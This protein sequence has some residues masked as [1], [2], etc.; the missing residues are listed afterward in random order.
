MD[1]LYDE[2]DYHNHNLDLFEQE[3]VELQQAAEQGQL[4]NDYIG[5]HCIQQEHI[6]QEQEQ[7]EQEQ[8][9]L[10]MD[11]FQEQEQEELKRDHFQEQ[12]VGHAEV[13]LN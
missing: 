6:Q 5:V 4:V 3:Q 12:D 11:H 2:P 8:E 13:T 9:E 1:G 7:E 10:K